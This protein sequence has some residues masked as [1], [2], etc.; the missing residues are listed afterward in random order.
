MGHQFV[1]V[2]AALGI[3]IVAAVF[4]RR[5]GIA[6][7]LL[8]VGLGIAASYVPTLPEIEIDPEIILVC[9]LPPLLY[10]SAVKLPV[11]DLRRNIV[12]IGWLSVVMVI[13]TALAI[14]AAVHLV[15]PQIPFALG[16]ALGAV[17]S[18]TDAV[19][20]TSIGRRLGLP[21]RIMTILEGESLVND[22]SS[23]VLLRTAVAAVAI[24]G[25]FDLGSA[26]LDFG[27]AVIGAIIIGGLVAVITVRVRQHLDDPV[28]NT[29]LSFAVPFLAYFPAEAGNTSGVLAVVVAGIVTGTL[30]ARRFSARDRQTQTITWSS[31]NFILENGVFLAM[32]FQLPTLFA[33]ARA[34]TSAGELTAMVALVVGL[35]IVL[36]FIGLTG[37]AVVLN[38]VTSSDHGDQ[39]RYQLARLGDRLD[40]ASPE[41][42]RDENRLDW[43]RRHL[44][45]TSADVAFREREPLTRRSLLVLGWAGMRG[46]VTV[47]AAQTIPIGPA[48][49][50]TVVLVAYL[51][52]II[53]LVA[54]G[55]TLPALIR[56]MHFSEPSPDERRSEFLDLLKRVGESA[57][58]QIGPID[59]Q[60]VDGEPIDPDVVESLRQRFIP[61]LLRG[62]QRAVA[63][64]KPGLR[65]QSLI[66]QRRYLDAMRENLLAERSIGADRSATYKQVEDML[67]REERGLAAIAE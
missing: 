31:I 33:A 66:V 5:T 3:I 59:E 52:A 56:R 9:V 42:S 41:S 45:R 12:M 14:G 28:L 43:A 40:R 34:Q 25:S 65:E 53:T 48:Y 7:P 37:P 60:K 11:L 67:D 16:V 23:L 64:S 62:D 54:F 61:M 46:V 36:R 2:G 15:F 47:A 13:V 6:A 44:A 22:A 21:P 39:V 20:A 38:L 27:W 32:G 49:R 35:L 55:L 63:R 18:P 8:L 57:I 4:A 17:V 58:D 19:A 29:T 30:G 24:T 10:S 50:D 26:V 51:V 1:L